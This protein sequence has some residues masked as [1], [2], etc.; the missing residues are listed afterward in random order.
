[1]STPLPRPAF[2]VCSHRIYLDHA[3]ISPLASPVRAAIEAHLDDC[4]ESGALAFGNVMDEMEAIRGRLAR[5]LGAAADEIAFVKNTTE[6]LSF[7]ANGL[8]LGEGDRVVV[9]GREFPSNYYPWIALRDRGVTVDVLEPV[10]TAQ[11]LPV[12]RFA[13]ALREGDP[14]AVV[15]VSWVQF[16]RGWRTDLAA[17]ADVCHERGS[18]LCVDLIQGAG[19]VPCDLG[20]WGVDLAAA[21][22]HKW[23]LGITGLGVL[24]V[25]REHLDRL[26]PSEPGW[27]SVAH[28]TE[29]DNRELV[30]DESARRFEGGGPSAVGVHAL[31]A[32]IDLLADAGLDTIWQH[33][34]RV[35]DHAADRLAEIGC[36]VLSDRGDGAS[37]IITAALPPGSPEAQDVVDALGD[38]GVVC[39]ARGG[40]VRLAPHGYNTTDEV[41]AVIDAIGALA[42]AG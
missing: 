12:D 28:R 4:A 34:R 40:G 30:Y 17:L 7:V 35:S 32:A 6:G 29:W 23:L 39:S 25:R 19:V 20:A 3:G 21:G 37:A 15:A 1:V 38:R 2:P 36:R 14:P 41:D 42:P 5:F 9:T 33:V 26:R 24:Y 8:G 31:G 18:L 27:A 16:G 11:A 10:G 22:G 13:D